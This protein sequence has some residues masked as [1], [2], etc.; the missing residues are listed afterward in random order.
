M[1]SSAWEGFGNVI[2]EALEQGTAVVSTD[3]EA[4]PREILADGEFG[5]LVPVGDAPALASAMQQALGEAHDAERL[6]QRAREFSVDRAVDAYLALLLPGADASHYAN[7]AGLG[8]ET[9]ASRP[10][11]SRKDACNR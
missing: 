7:E 11:S 8:L 4:G 3:C 10:Q 1:L 2:V 5:T 9:S 6:R